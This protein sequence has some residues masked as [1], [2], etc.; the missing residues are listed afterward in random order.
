MFL[1]VCG[2]SW[3][4]CNDST[5]K[6]KI[7]IYLIVSL[8]LQIS[9]HDYHS[10]SFLN[11]I[12]SV[13]I[14]RSQFYVKKYF[15]GENVYHQLRREW[16]PEKGKLIPNIR[17]THGC[18]NFDKIREWASDRV[19][20]DLNPTAH[21]G[22]LSNNGRRLPCKLH[23]PFVLLPIYMKAGSPTTQNYQSS[24]FLLRSPTTSNSPILRPT[25]LQRC[26]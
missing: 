10:V 17:T 6:P 3:Y 4:R 13:W 16:N 22:M 12:T 19:V 23:G 11:H 5:C 25:K 9:K 21:P 7:S 24:G 20:K 1:P 15:C 2:I 18:K 26:F 8:V 14:K